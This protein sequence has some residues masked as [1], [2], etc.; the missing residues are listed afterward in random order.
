MGC[1]SVLGAIAVV[2]SLLSTSVAAQS[3]DAPS[4]GDE[5]FVPGT[6]AA[7]SPSPWDPPCSPFSWPLFAV[8]LDH[9][10]ELSLSAAQVEGL[11]RLCL[12]FIREAIRRQ[13]DLGLALLDLAALLRP[14]PTDPAKPV[15]MP[16]AEAAVRE[17]ER[18]EADLHIA[19]LRA[20][21]AGKAQLT[22]DQRSKLAA[23]M[24]GDD[25][26]KPGPAAP[27]GAP[28][29]LGSTS[30]AQDAPRTEGRPGAPGTHPGGFP[31]HPVVPGAPA[32][33]QP[34][35]SYVEP[36]P[37][38]SYWYYCASAGAYYPSIQTCDRPWV[39]VPS[40]TQ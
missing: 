27:P 1:K 34:P 14:D 24:A 11:E 20:V 37:P 9:R 21:E 7:P 36:P 12:D 10:G 8:I 30:P 32:V 4:Q 28:G 22:A 13:A 16:K 5:R 17:I 29:R 2:L 3:R 40:W 6:G 39:A 35:P 26:P 31:P 19:R 23:L 33:R 18:V 15:D 38:G 25:R